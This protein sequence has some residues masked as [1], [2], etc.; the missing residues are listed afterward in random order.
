MPSLLAAAIF[1][2]A[3][4][5][6]NATPAAPTEPQEP[7]ERQEPQEPPKVEVS[8]TVEATRTGSR[9]EDSPLRVEVLEREEIE[10]K[11]LMT[12]GDI[13]MMLNEMGGM[14]VQAT[15][16][17]LG[18]ASVRVQGMRGRYT[19]FLSDGLPLFGEVGGLGLLQIPP[20]DLGQVEVIKGVASSLY[21]AGAMGGVINL[22][23]R[24]PGHE[25][26][27]E[28]LI[29]RS[30]LGGT[31][32]VT[33]FGQPLG[34]GW[35]LTF[36]GGGHWQERVDVN[37]D[38]WSDLPRYSRGIARPRL[39]WSDDKGNRVFATV[40]ITVEDREG[41]SPSH[42]EALDTRAFDAG[43]LDQRIVRGTYL[44]TTRAAMSSKEHDHLFGAV[45][46][47]DRHTTGFGEVTMRGAA[48]AHTWVAGAAVEIDHYHNDDVPQ[49]D[50]AFTIPGAFVQDDVML[51]PWLSMSG[52][53]RLDYHSEYGAFVSP[54]VSALL[55]SG[56]W[57]G[58]ASFGTGFFGPSALTEETEAAGLTRLAMPQPL[59]A[60][61]GRS[62][63]IDIT[64]TSG[65]ISATVTL[66]TSR[67]GDSITVDR[68]TEYAIRNAEKTTNA[69][70]ELLAT[71]RAEPFAVTGTYTYVRSREFDA[72]GITDV[73]L[74]PRHSGGVVAMWEKEDIGRIGVELY[75]T[76]WQRLESN[77]YADR[78]EPY[79]I[80]GV[81]GERQ[82]GRIRLFINGENL[83]GVRQTEWHPLERPAPG[84]DGRMTVD[85]W[86]PLEG[87]NINGG[88]RV[89]F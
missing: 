74:T 86:A 80:V 5:A 46:E 41:G 13:V 38:T 10:E 69:G 78:S 85:A 2:I 29:N 6:G 21:G 42:V 77:P 70:V 64:R 45:R 26:V 33:F 60:E 30:T 65:P 35:G 75:Y 27:R 81:L 49:F 66:F 63:S 53:A 73:A 59:L 24:V 56:A 72:D 54:R 25:P 14:R 4:V 15:S 34:G 87:R 71:W 11:M 9:I 82:F 55:R 48:G 22:V 31:D 39:F 37:D 62:A 20:M 19:R 40:G 7:Q 61:T 18:A 44:I 47:H 76:G 43:Y 1:A 68:D 79:A 50:H 16:P 17:S 28:L 67:V 84:A 23:S 88:V 83:T 32:A 36:L 3:Q 89:R 8:I 52:S 51:K 58:R 12:P 57:S